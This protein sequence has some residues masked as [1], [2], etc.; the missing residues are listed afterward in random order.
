MSTLSQIRALDPAS[1]TTAADAT[2]TANIAFGKATDQ[3]DRH[4]DHAFST[5]HG[6]AAVAAAARAWSDRVVGRGIANAVAEQV[7][8]L[9]AASAALIPAR[10]NV[11]RIADN[12]SA[13]GFTVHDDGT[14]VPPRCDTGD[15]RADTVGQACLDDEALTFEVQLKSALTSFD[16]LD[17][18]AADAIDQTTIRLST[19]GGD[20]RTQGLWTLGGPD[21][22]ED[23][24]L[25]RSGRARDSDL[26]RIGRA[27]SSDSGVSIEYLDAFYNGLGQDELT[28]LF[29][30]FKQWEADGDP[31]AAGWADAVGNGLLTLSNPDYG[32][33]WGR[34]PQDIRD[35]LH[36]GYEP[37]PREPG[38]A[39]R[40]DRLDALG[41]MLGE[42]NPEY[43]PGAQM[44]VE[45]NRVAGYMAGVP[46]YADPHVVP[47]PDP[48]YYDKTAR[49]FLD[50]G[51]RN[52]DASYHLL[53][54][55][56]VDGSPAQ[57]DRDEVLVPLLTREWEDDGATL[58]G[59]TDW[60]AADAIPPDPTDPV[61]VA[62]AERAGQAAFGLAESLS[63]PESG[64][65]GSNNFD[66]FLHMP[67]TDGLLSDRTIGEVNPLAVQS[68]S[69]AL[70]PY[71]SDM[72]GADEDATPTHGFGDLGPVPATRVF[73]LLDTDPAAGALAN[74]AALAQATDFDRRFALDQVGG[75]GKYSYGT[76]SGRLQSL[77][78][79]GL[80]SA[81]ENERAIEQ[82][83][84]DTR[85]QYR[86]DA[87]AV[88]QT[89]VT[90]AV[91]A[92]PGGMVAGPM[93]YSTGVLLD[94]AIINAE[95]Q[96]VGHA[97]GIEGLD[98]SMYLTETSAQNTIRFN[99]LQ[100]LSESGQVNAASLPSDWTEE[101]VLRERKDIPDSKLTNQASWILTDAGIRRDIQDAYLI[102]A[103]AGQQDLR[104]IIY[105]DQRD[106]EAGFREVL[107]GD[108][109]A[110]GGGRWAYSQ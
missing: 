15:S 90:G 101:G 63:S 98:T 52:P 40:L 36:Y 56:G 27:L 28:E 26:E 97:S 107:L 71:A 49:T 81:Y 50:I 25:V 70:A 13:A 55:T 30:T 32:G 109:V 5:W 106:G 68:F 96:Y 66:R 69:E 4:V 84:I 110:A 102:T 94:S 17:N 67:E 79:V 91:T 73:T 47:T 7:D 43:R 39:I 18:D 58:A 99:M 42:A 104:S 12:A 1:L 44:G 23:A 16:Q 8:A 11:V 86:S 83:A 60:I 87:Y 46:T 31:G 53:S 62:R 108:A 35:T 78:E 65:D 14:V 22:H 20:F 6:D 103:D 95:G 59:L 29:A 54:G 92:L 75:E 105:A 85:N 74:G 41:T 77:V 89:L 100:A 19:F 88:A 93:A 51:T 34:V 76:Y 10:D 64:W 37:G 3:V 82:A 45:L 21:G 2:E 48:S 24:E 57:F 80:S 72:V 61:D 33:G 9:R 38:S